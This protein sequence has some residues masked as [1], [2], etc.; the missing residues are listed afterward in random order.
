MDDPPPPPRAQTHDGC[1]Q[2]T[3]VAVLSGKKAN[4]E[5]RAF[6]QKLQ[7]ENATLSESSLQS[8]TTKV[9]PSSQDDVEPKDTQLN[10]DK[11]EGCHATMDER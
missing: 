7:R 1:V 8:D 6:L 2:P 9:P 10:H 3:K 11:K 4:K 5:Y